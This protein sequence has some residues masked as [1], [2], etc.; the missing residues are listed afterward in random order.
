MFG[1]FVLFLKIKVGIV[2]NITGFLII[3]LAAMTWMPKIYGLDDRATEIF[4]SINTTTLATMKTRG[5][6][7]TWYIYFF[8]LCRNTKKLFLLEREKRKNWQIRQ[9]CYLPPVWHVRR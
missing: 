1:L 6:N 9:F 8:L 5:Q 3:F 4:F 7:C 2:M